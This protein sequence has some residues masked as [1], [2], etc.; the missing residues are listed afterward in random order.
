[1]NGSSRNKPVV[2]RPPPPVPQT[3]P[4]ICKDLLLIDFSDIPNR[5]SSPEKATQ[6]NQS[7]FTLRIPPPPP[8]PPPSSEST[9]RSPQPP[10]RFS[11]N[12]LDSHQ[13]IAQVVTGVTEQLKHD[14]PQLNS[15]SPQQFTPPLVRRFTIPYPSTYYN[16]QRPQ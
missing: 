16:T 9:R 11:T 12:P 6:S 15:S 10:R 14:F 3:A 13:F 2:T 7:S 5:K 1:M 8:P 4:T